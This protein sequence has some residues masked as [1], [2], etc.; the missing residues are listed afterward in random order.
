VF[1]WFTFGFLEFSFS[2]PPPRPRDAPLGALRAYGWFSTRPTLTS[3]GEFWCSCAPTPASAAPSGSRAN[4]LLH[5]MLTSRTIQGSV[6]HAVVGSQRLL[7]QHGQLGAAP[8]PPAAAITTTAP[9]LHHY[10]TT[11]APLLLLLLLLRLPATAAR[12]QRSTSRH[13]DQEAHV[14]RYSSPRAS[15]SR[16]FSTRAR[17]WSR[18]SGV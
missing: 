4:T 10:C 17:R 1:E 2:F 15:S 14:A 12:T 3:S 8:P 18:I 9:L 11:T 16:R 6:E 5:G 13:T 7:R